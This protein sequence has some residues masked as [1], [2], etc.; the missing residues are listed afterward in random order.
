MDM[1]MHIVDD[2]TVMG[3]N[4]AKEAAKR[5]GFQDCRSVLRLRRDQRTAKID[6]H[7]PLRTPGYNHVAKDRAEGA[8]EAVC[9]LIPPA[10]LN[11]A[12]GFQQFGCSEV[13]DGPVANEWIGGVEQPPHLLERLGRAP[14]D[15]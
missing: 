7:V 14:F 11:R 3:L 6:G 2:V 12:V 13:C 8:A 5:L 15:L 10:R 9:R 4:R 1:A